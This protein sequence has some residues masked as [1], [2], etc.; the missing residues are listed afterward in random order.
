MTASRKNHRVNKEIVK[1]KV[2]RVVIEESDEEKSESNEIDELWSRICDLNNMI[3]RVMKT[4]QE[5]VKDNLDMKE[6]LQSLEDGM[7]C[8]R[9]NELDMIDE[10]MK[11]LLEKEKVTNEK[12]A[13]LEKKLEISQEELGK[14][15]EYFQKQLEDFQPAG[16]V[17]ESW[18]GVE[19]NM[20][21][22]LIYVK[23][24]LNKRIKK[25]EVD[26]VILNLRE[27]VNEL[28]KM[29]EV[30]VSVVHSTPVKD[31][32]RANNGWRKN[33][34]YHSPVHS[35]EKDWWKKKRKWYRPLWCD[36]H[37]WGVHTTSTCWATTKKKVWRVKEVKVS[38]KEIGG[39]ALPGAVPAKIQ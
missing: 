7:F 17:D 9:E 11:E 19:E 23:N 24:K 38:D 14:V 39:E 34:D 13:T 35:P 25:E 12:V 4:N 5:L 27:E 16:K 21:G 18:K 33:R 28:K 30:N 20:M 6:K 10:K 26:K 31:I 37:G 36:T 29:I 32:D 22:E 2:K 8:L 3:E 1:K 15:R